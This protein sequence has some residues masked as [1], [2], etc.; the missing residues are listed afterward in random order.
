M[1]LQSIAL[2]S[3]LSTSAHF[4]MGGILRGKASSPTTVALESAPCLSP[5]HQV[6]VCATAGCPSL[7]SVT[8]TEGKELTLTGGLLPV[9][10]DL[11]V[12]AIA[13]LSGFWLELRISPCP[14]ASIGLGCASP[15]GIAIDRG[16]PPAFIGQPLQI[17]GVE[18]GVIT[19][20][21][22]DTQ[23]Q[24][25]VQTDRVVAATAKGVAIA[26]YSGP[27]PVYQGAAAIGTTAH[28]T[29]K[30]VDRLSGSFSLSLVR[31]WK[32]DT[33]R[34]IPDVIDWSTVLASGP[35]SVV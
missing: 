27:A 17:A 26:G 29:W 25:L 24:S 15:K 7:L 1:D 14:P 9:G 30:P 22:S 33:S 5:G 18:A 35:Y 6:A 10:E 4:T 2:G 31:G 23:G 12:Q 21:V 19:G 16:V 20:V 3:T 28:L 8:A 32:G 13:N 11:T 34:C